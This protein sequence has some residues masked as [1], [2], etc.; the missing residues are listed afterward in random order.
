MEFGLVY[1]ALVQDHY[2]GAGDAA[3]FLGVG[4]S[5]GGLFPVYVA[6]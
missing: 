3:V 5:Q 1:E 4:V 2:G 6:G